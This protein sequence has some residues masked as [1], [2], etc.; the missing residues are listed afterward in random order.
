MKVQ[1]LRSMPERKRIRVIIDTNIFIS[2]LIGKRLANLRQTIVNSFIQL[3]FSEQIIRE[4]KVV[5][6]RPKFKKYFNPDDV[7]DL[8]DLINTIGIIFNITREPDICRDPKDNFLLAL[9]DKGTVDYLV[10]GDTD[11]ILIKEYKGTKIITM[12]LKQYTNAYPV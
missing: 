4:L 3:V 10:T 1:E 5:T 8:I 6:S 11:L 12:L 2:F 9:S 7:S